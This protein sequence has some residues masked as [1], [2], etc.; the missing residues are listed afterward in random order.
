MSAE[1][2]RKII[3]TFQ[4]SHSNHERH[5]FKTQIAAARKSLTKERLLIEIRLKNIQEEI[6]EKEYIL[7]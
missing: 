1:P 2:G 7:A 3:K 4:N 5:L 6:K